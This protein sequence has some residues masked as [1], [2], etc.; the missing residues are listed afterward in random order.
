MEDKRRALN[1]VVKP[2][3]GIAA[4]NHEITIESRKKCIF[5]LEDS[6]ACSDGSRKNAPS[7]GLSSGSR[8]N[9]QCCSD[10]QRRRPRAIAVLFAVVAACLVLLSALVS[11]LNHSYRIS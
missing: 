8:R 7:F 5:V 10:V 9:I 1:R 11:L 2:G 6:A 4:N 3:K